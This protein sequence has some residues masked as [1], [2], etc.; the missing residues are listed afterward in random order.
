M[1]TVCVAMLV[2]VLLLIGLAGCG[3]GRDPA[4]PSLVKVTGVVTLDGKPLSRVA[5]TFIPVGTTL[6]GR[7]HGFTDVSGVY[8]LVTDQNE[9]GAAVGEYKVLCN[10]WVQADGSDYPRD[11]KVSPIE[12]NGKEKLPPRYSDELSSELKATVPAGGGAVDLKLVSKR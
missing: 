4:L 10:K 5:V 8:G 7:C 6:G 9:K 1:R 2:P 11:S 12:S 3:G